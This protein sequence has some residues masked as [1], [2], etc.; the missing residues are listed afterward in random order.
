MNVVKADVPGEPLQYPRQFVV[1]TAF[2]A[3]RDKIPVGM[4]GPITPFIIMLDIEQ[5][6]ASGCSHD[7]D[8]NMHQQVLSPT[9]DQDQQAHHRQ[10]SQVG[11][12][13]AHPFAFPSAAQDEPVRDDKYIDWSYG[14]HDQWMSKQTVPQSFHWGQCLVFIDS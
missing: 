12:D 14:E 7:N 10:D 9:H 13:D 6:H 2:E 11:D 5:P 8:R 4:A 3:S 1:G